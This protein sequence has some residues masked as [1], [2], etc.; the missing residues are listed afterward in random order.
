MY[1][2]VL[3]LNQAYRTSDARSKHGFATYIE[4]LH[5]DTESPSATEF[6]RP[7]EEVI[8]STTQVWK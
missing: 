6:P 2:Y 1:R 5:S 3:E 7:G 8:Y 4:S